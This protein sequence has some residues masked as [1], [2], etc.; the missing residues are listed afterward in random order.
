M[1]NRYPSPVKITS[2]DIAEKLNKLKANTGLEPFQND[3][4][5]SFTEFHKS[6]GYLTD[7][8]YA[9]LNKIYEANSDERVSEMQKWRDNFTDEMKA[10]F[11]ICCDYYDHTGYFGNIVSQWKKDKDYIPTQTQYEKICCNT[12]AKKVLDN[13]NRPTL[14]NNGDL[15]SLRANWS[16]SAVKF[17]E[18][19]S[20]HN[21]HT[22]ADS[23]KTCM[24]VDNKVVQNDLHRYCKVFVLS[25]PDIVMLVREKDLK[26]FRAGK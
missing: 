15:V 13:H 24:V 21:W 25:H 7:R 12:Y 10:N 3:L 2:D 11:R 9:L 18:K 26:Q 22:S 23:K 16:M 1:N 20:F 17:V 6:K 14:F 5:A 4:V 8:Q 19:G